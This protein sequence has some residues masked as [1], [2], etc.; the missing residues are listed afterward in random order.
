MD[1][2]GYNKGGVIRHIKAPARVKVELLDLKKKK[3]I[4]MMRNR[5]KYFF[6]HWNDRC[7]SFFVHMTQFRISL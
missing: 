1:I 5:V 6:K 7:M 4:V 2:L 3:K